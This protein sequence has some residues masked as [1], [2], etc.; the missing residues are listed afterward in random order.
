MFKRNPTTGNKLY[1]VHDLDLWNNSQYGHVVE[2]LWGKL[3]RSVSFTIF[4]I[5][6]CQTILYYRGNVNSHQ[7]FIPA[8]QALYELA[9]LAVNVDAKNSVAPAIGIPSSTLG[10]R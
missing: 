2:V 6:D 9:V 8:V 1:A 3:G 7:A 10:P 5:Q 4:R